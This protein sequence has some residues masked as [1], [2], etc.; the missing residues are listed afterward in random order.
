MASQPPSDAPVQSISPNYN[1]QR[2]WIARTDTVD[3]SDGGF[4][5][6]PTNP[7]LHSHAT[8]LPLTELADYPALVLL[9]E[10][11]IGKSTALKVEA[12]RVATN[13]AASNTISIHVDLRA[14]SSELLLHKRVFESAEFFAWTQGTSHLVLHIDSLDEALL[15]IDSIA[16]LLAE[17]LP[18][19]P[20]SRMSVRIA[21]RT[22]VWPTGTLEP[23]LRN[24][25]GD[26]AVGVFELAPLR[27]CDVVSA[28]EAQGIDPEVFI[29]ELYAANAVPFAIKPLTLNLLF[30]LFKKEGRMPRSV[31]EIYRRGCLKLCEESNPSRRDARR[32]GDLSPAQR[33]R[34][35]SRIAATTMFANRYAVWRGPEAGVPE[36]DVTLSAITGGR[37]EGEFPAFEVTED[38]VRE[39]LDTGLFTSRGGVRMGWAHQSYAEF[40]AA[41]YIK[42]LA[43]NN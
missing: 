21:C 6:D 27:R 10:P 35:A 11:G 26:A 4:F 31:A 25:W 7:L 14:Y 5:T 33:L 15:R 34:I 29:R 23:A 8:A 16:N 18:R 41:L 42:A 40:L 20:A 2:F 43:R 19:Y 38:S 9:G 13:A 17:E 30:S 22:A 12:H 39:V 24:I 3:L 28:A 32:L 37:E 1:W 36:E